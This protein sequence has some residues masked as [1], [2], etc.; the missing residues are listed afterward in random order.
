MN[1]RR[2]AGISLIEISLVV[3]ILGISALTVIPNFSAS[4]PQRL[5]LAAN[6]V[7]E[8]LRFARNESIRTGQAHGVLL[9]ADNSS[10]GR[11]ISVYK[12]N[13]AAGPKDLTYLLYHPVSRQPYDLSMDEASPA[14]GV[15]LSSA[16]KPFHFDGVSGP[17]S[18]LHFDPAGRPVRVTSGSTS[19]MTGGDVQLTYGG[20]TQ[21]V[22][23]SPVTGR[24]QLQ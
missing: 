10:A 20:Q 19:R 2:E 4:D 13:P 1:R 18:Y 15:T 21:T 3:A 11:D 6:R 9:D 23:V 12:L 7:A 17:R 22:S 24:V 5:S 14:A 16:G 8:A